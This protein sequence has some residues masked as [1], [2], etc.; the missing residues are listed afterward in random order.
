MIKII[1]K[2]LNWTAIILGSIIL[3]LIIAAAIIIIRHDR[4]GL[5]ASGGILSKNQSRYD[6]IFY[7]LNLEVK[8][9]E[10]SIVI[11]PGVYIDSAI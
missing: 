1:K 9:S 7:D 5:Y 4:Y 8:S 3:L 11:L 2:I 10:Q 6:V